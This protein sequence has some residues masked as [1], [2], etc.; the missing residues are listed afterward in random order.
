[1]DA[2]T[3]DT[4]TCTNLDKSIGLEWLCTNG[5]GSFASG[6]VS[7]VNTRKY[8]GYLTVAARPPVERYVMLAHVEDRLWIGDRSHALSANEFPD[9][10]DPA[11]YENMVDFSYL[12]GPTWHYRCGDALIEKSLVLVHGQDT[13]CIR[14]KLLECS[15]QCEPLRLHVQPMLAGRH[16][17]ATTTAGN[18]PQWQ[19]A[20]RS[21]ARDSLMLSTP[22]CPIRLFI[23][24][25]ADRFSD[26]SC[27]W[28]NFMLRAEA[29]RGY[30]DRD[31]LWTPGA[32]EFSLTPGKCVGLICATRPVAF[33]EQDGIFANAA[34]RTQSLVLKLN[35]TSEPGQLAQKLSVA[36]DQFVVSR[37][38]EKNASG[39]MSVIAGYPWFEDWG[40]DTFISLPGLSLVTGRFDVAKS[41]LVTFADHIRDG[42]VPNRFPDESDHADYN[43]VDA[44][45]WFIHAAYQYWRYSGDHG[46]LRDYLYAPLNQIIDCYRA[47]TR[48]GIRMDSDGLIRA[49]EPG[50]Q[51]TWMDAKI[52]NDVVTPRYG[53]PVEINALWFN[54]LKIMET[55]AQ[56]AGRLSRANEL[57]A[58]AVKVKAAFGARFWNPAAGCLFDVIADDGYGDPAIRPNQ[59]ISLGL[60]FGMLDDSKSRCILNVVQQKLLTPMGLRT[61]APGSPGY[62]GRYM[63]DQNSRDHAYHQGTAWPWLIGPFVSG[64]I[65]T[66]GATSQT[67]AGAWGFLKPFTAH[68]TQTGLGSISEIA[69]GDS[70]YTPRGC[71][72]QAWSVA[73]VLR[74]LWEDVLQKAPPWPHEVP[75]SAKAAPVS[76][77]GA[78]K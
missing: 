56:L 4:Q 59:I 44:S 60:P 48:Y 17:H 38:G 6:T 49:G 50:V 27:W 3:C 30:P 20:D 15:T 66:L 75:V 19:L 71:F 46:L 43:T 55:V 78:V 73:E 9:V 42:L 18:R 67:R 76:M 25:N 31:D 5:L 10:I 32:L 39:K 69:D 63:G 29:A 21:S 47:G 24:H 68:L 7:G 1:M 62:Q 26:G 57:A 34:K 33:T 41:I 52:G 37:V 13:V 14:Y 72:A 22:Q 65:K 40:R 35:D 51:L 74:S 58:L 16:F 28:Y 36:A 70:P 53:K 64:Y 45:L 2:I 8:H 77:A 23:S 12:N 11:G 61:L 54:A